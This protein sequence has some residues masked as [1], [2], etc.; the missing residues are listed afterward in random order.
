MVVYK[1]SLL[2]FLFIFFLLQRAECASLPI[3][4][5]L[6]SDRGNRPKWSR[7]T[8]CPPCSL[9][10]SIKKGNKFVYF[11]WIFH[12]FMTGLEVHVY[13]VVVE[14]REVLAAVWLRVCV[15]LD[16]LLLARDVLSTVRHL[17]GL[18]E[19]DHRL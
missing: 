16:V 15:D 4:W 13:P 5:C 7:S 8:R 2:F 9:A 14:E 19:F 18:R 17:L 6:W 3:L 1:I 12:D 11:C 10:A